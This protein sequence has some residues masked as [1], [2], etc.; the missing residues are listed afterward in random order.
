MRERADLADDIGGRR[1]PEHG[2]Q[3]G[4]LVRCGPGAQGQ[5]ERLT[6]VHTKETRATA[7][8]HRNL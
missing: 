4:D 1:F 7:G 8:T 2:A 3:P 6:G 5:N